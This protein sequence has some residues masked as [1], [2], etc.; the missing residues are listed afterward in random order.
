MS[1]ETR[2]RQP[3]VGKELD[4]EDGIA[5][6]TP[7]RGVPSYRSGGGGYLARPHTCARTERRS[8]ISWP[9]GGL[10]LSLGWTYHTPNSRYTG[11]RVNAGVEHDS[12][13]RMPPCTSQRGA[14]APRA[15]ACVTYATCSPRLTAK[16]GTSPSLVVGALPPI[17]SWDHFWYT[18]PPFETTVKC[19]LDGGFKSC[20][21]A[22][23]WSHLTTTCSSRTVQ[24]FRQWKRTQT[25][26]GNTS[27]PR[28]TPHIASIGQKNTH[29]AKVSRSSEHIAF[30]AKK[31]L[32]AAQ[33]SSK[34]VVREASR[35]MAVRLCMFHM[36][37]A[38]AACCPAPRL[39]VESVA[40]PQVHQT[41][42]GTASAWSAGVAHRV[43]GACDAAERRWRSR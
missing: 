19:A 17:F 10:N 28:R 24:M 2:G 11:E 35:E 23:S 9:F 12:R 30:H 4:T 34:I 37:R 42:E 6:L 29:L 22:F 26:D 20:I 39:A 21:L 18:C 16:S 38:S 27:Q 41:G 31:T 15:I 13:G 32:C 1:G 3:V 8:R 7:R 14:G 33:P 5:H 36:S 25:C 40:W 43:A